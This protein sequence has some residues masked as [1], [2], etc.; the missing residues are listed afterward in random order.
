MRNKP[1]LDQTIC[2]GNPHCEN[3]HFS[4]GKAYE[5]APLVVP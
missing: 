3:S 4:R 5:K 2:I 1:I